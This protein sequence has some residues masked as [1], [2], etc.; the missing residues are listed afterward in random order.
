MGKRILILLGHPDPRPERFCR[1]LAEAY[2]AGAVEAGHDVA[3]IDIA[4]LD[5]SALKSKLEWEAPIA[6]ALRVPQEAIAW[7]EHLVIVF[8]LWLG[9]MPALLKA[10]F[11]QVLRPRF[12]FEQKGPGRWDK[13]LVGRSARIVVTMGMSDFKVSM[14][15]VVPDTG[16]NIAGLRN[17]I[18]FLVESRGVGIGRAHFRRRVETH[19][20]A[21]RTILD[22]TAK[23]APAIL[24]L[25]RH[26]SEDAAAAAGKGEVVVAS[27]MT[28]G[29]HTLVMSASR[30]RTTTGTLSARAPS[31]SRAADSAC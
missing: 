7:A 12:A 24:A 6:D 11:E 25:V 8:P 22:L 3:V 17:E 9:T 29:R 27:A 10:F 2:H 1:A 4:R 19:L 28:P 26:A 13:K 30:K 15:G 18:S 16:R 5:F 21:N 23:N 31:K 20:V 14:G